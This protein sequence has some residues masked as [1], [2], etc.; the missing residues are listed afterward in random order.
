MAVQLIAV[1]CPACGADISVE[2]TREF[3]FCTYCGTKILMN[4]ENEHIYRNIDEARIKEAE[5]DRM[6]RLR[7]LELEEKENSRG[8]KSI[9]LAYGIA[10][11]FVL[12]GA[13]ICLAN[14]AA[15]AVGIMIGAYIALFTFIKSDEKKKTK[16]KYVGA[17]EV[18]IT[19]SM[20]DYS[21]K[22]FN[23]VVLLFRGAGF[24][25]VTAI[26]LND[27]TMFNQRKNGQVESV[28]IN[29]SDEFEEGDIF[30]KNS[31]VL[32]TYHSK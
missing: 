28:T 29:G 12:V 11:A 14:G 15:G 21:E 4:N 23:S 16:R 2:S 24:A 30:P 3:S 13:L 10:L 26:P 7:E 31:N 9:F 1:K 8:R 6:I 17:N 19:E 32:I 18:V 25:N 5:T 22:N 20:E 27:L